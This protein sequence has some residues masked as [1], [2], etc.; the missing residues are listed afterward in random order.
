MVIKCRQFPQ[1]GG[2]VDGHGAVCVPTGSGANRAVEA[3]LCGCE[4]S[5]ISK[6]GEDPLGEMAKASLRRHKINTE[7]VFSASA[8]STGLIMTM[9]DSKGENCSCVS[10]GANRALS[11]DD[12]AS[13]SSESL[14][15]AADVCL[16]DGHLPHDAVVMAIRMA[17]LHKTR[18]ILE[19]FA[20]D[21]HGAIPS[22]AGLDWPTEFYTVDILIPRMGRY[23]DSLE[24]GAATAG[25]MKVL[26]SDFV[27]KGAGCVI[28]KMGTRGVFLVDR[29]D[30][31]HIPWFNLDVVDRTAAADAFGGALAASIG[32]GD[33]IHTAVKF[34]AAAGAIALSKFGAQDS[35][36][37][38][39]KI[40]ELLQK[41]E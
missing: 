4:V 35:L 29:N 14:I 5:L 9:V 11:A 17:Q 10:A 25:E 38:K 22:A 2:T 32:A 28:M 12:I 18:T 24:C 36:P 16:I 33:D 30:S 40:I 3:A 31:T 27:A 15:G 6:V 23:T 8:M 34:A 37:K 41:G 19:A 26:A 7:H 21:V 13:V 20:E 39:E 1:P